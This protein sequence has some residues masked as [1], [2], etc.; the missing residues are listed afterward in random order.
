MQKSRRLIYIY[1]WVAMQIIQERHYMTKKST[2]NK[3]RPIGNQKLSKKKCIL[4][5][6]GM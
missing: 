3:L 2:A 6:T 1:Q 4:D 5:Q